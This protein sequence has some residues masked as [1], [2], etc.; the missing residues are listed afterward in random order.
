MNPFVNHVLA[1]NLSF[2]GLL[3]W[4]STEGAN[5]VLVAGIIFCIII[6]FKKH[7][8]GAIGTFVVLLI[9]YAFVKNPQ[10]LGD[11]SEFFTSKMGIS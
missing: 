3:D 5:L 6:A 8:I 7:L 4:F 2:D 10:L 1:V 9:A 11:I